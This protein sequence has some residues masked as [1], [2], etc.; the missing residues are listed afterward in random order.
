MNCEKIMNEKIIIAIFGLSGVI[1]GALLQI[2]GNIIVEYYKTKSTK[3]INKKRKKLLLTM[4]NVDK[5]KWRKINTLM[6]VIG[7]DEETTRQLL[8][9]IGSRGSETDKDLWGLISRNPINE[10]I[11]K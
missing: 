2:F 11:Q 8:I 6:N 3:L 4:L 10:I 1:V 5:Y 9:E 7:A